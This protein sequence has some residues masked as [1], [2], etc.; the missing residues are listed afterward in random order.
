MRA[1]IPVFIGWIA[2]SRF[3]VAFAQGRWSQARADYE[4]AAALLGGLPTA[5]HAAYLLR[6]LG[7]L[8]VAEGQREVGMQALE[9]AVALGER[10]HDLQLLRDAQ[11]VLAECDLLAGQAAAAR[12]RLEPLLDQS[13]DEERQVTALLPLLAW[14]SLELGE[15]VRAETLAAAS[16]RRATEG[17]Y[18]L[19]LVDALRVAA[20]VATRQGQ[21]HA[22]EAALEEALGLCR[23][24]SY[25]YAEAKALYVYGQLHLAQDEPAQ[26]RERFEQ[27]LAICGR[28]GERFYAEHIE[29]ALTHL[30][31]PANV[32]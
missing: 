13:E 24:M 3:W 2:V 22:A 26:A 8:D 18:R 30:E 17:E 21:W 27:A 5:W 19:A 11:Q 28:L 15:A 4:R 32:P 31:R 23:A 20:L 25:P 14:S 7:A 1:G 6:D 12:R 10:N 16:R 9:Q 29:R